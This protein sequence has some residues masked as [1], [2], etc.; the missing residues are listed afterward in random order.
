M[1]ILHSLEAR[2]VCSWL[3]VNC[4]P[5]VT[6]KSGETGI[7]AWLIWAWIHT[8]RNPGQFFYY[9]ME[10]R[11]F[12]IC[13]PPLIPDEE[14]ADRPSPPGVT[15]QWDALDRSPVHHS[16]HHIDHSQTDTK[17]LQSPKCKSTTSTCIQAFQ[18]WSLGC[19]DAVSS[20]AAISQADQTSEPKTRTDTPASSGRGLLTLLFG[21]WPWLTLHK[22]GGGWV[23]SFSRKTVKKTWLFWLKCP[24]FSGSLYVS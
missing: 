24:H 18:S 13:S 12:S 15:G 5:S 14:V 16:G 6:L 2:L 8:P 17:R 3:R 1:I 21:I 22:P 11:I 9:K 4:L 23:C 19:T 20:K 7:T 10:I